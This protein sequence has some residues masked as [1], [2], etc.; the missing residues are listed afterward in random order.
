VY[1]VNSISLNGKASVTVGDCSPKNP[2]QYQPVIINIVGSGGGT[3]MDIGGNGIANGTFNSSLMQFQYSGTGGINLHG[4]GSSA[5]VIFAPNAP[6]TLSGNGTI[7]GS[8]IGASILG[9]GNPVTIH[10]DRALAA[11]LMTV[12]NWTLD[13]FTWS[14]Y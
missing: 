7:Y 11:N 12:G 6:V 8:V 1:Y 9:N 2:G 5:A 13:T 10:Y 14:K 3:V 4:N